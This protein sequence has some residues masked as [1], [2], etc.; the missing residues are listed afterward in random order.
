MIKARQ[1]MAKISKG[2]NHDSTCVLRELLTNVRGAVDDVE[3]I[4]EKMRK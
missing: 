3:F 2:I 4:F 1:I